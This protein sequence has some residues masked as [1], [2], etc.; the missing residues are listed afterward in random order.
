MFFP[1]FLLHLPLT[2][3]TTPPL[4]SH[5]HRASTMPTMPPLPTKIPPKQKP[6]FT[7]K[8]KKASKRQSPKEPESN[9]AVTHAHLAMTSPNPNTGDLRRP[10]THFS[11]FS[12]DPQP[13]S[14][15][16]TS[17][18]KHQS[19]PKKKKKHPQN[20]LD[21]NPPEKMNHRDV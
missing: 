2:S 4:P 7:K 16:P 13:T 8:K 20:L 6:I 3:N 15:I 10:T 19:Q 21:R 14:A 11:H 17:S 9:H 5:H 1:N 12:H 18:F